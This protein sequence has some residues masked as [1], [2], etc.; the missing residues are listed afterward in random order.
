[1]LLLECLRLG[2]RQQRASDLAR[3]NHQSVGW[4]S[5]SVDQAASWLSL[6]MSD[7]ADADFT[8]TRPFDWGR[9]S[10]LRTLWLGLI[11]VVIT[12]PLWL[13]GEREASAEICVVSGS[14]YMLIA[15]TVQWSM[16][17]KSGHRCVHGVRLHHVEFDRLTLVSPPQSGHVTIQG[18]AF[19]YVAQP[20]FD[21]HDSF[22]LTVSGAVSKRRGSSTILVTVSVVGAHRGLAAAGP[23]DVPSSGFPDATN[24]GVPLGAALTP[25]GS[26][27]ISTAGAVVSGLD[28]TGEVVITAPNVTLRNCKVRATTFVGI[29][30]TG[31]GALIENCEVM[32]VYANGSTKGIWF[33]DTATGSTVRKCNIHDVEDGVYVSTRNIAVTDN[34][35]HDLNSTGFDPHYDGIQ[36]H[37]GVTSDVTIHHNSVVVAL[38][39]NSAITMGTVQNVLIDGNRLSGGGYTI[40][41]DGRFGEGTVSRVFITNNRFG[42]HTVDHMTFERATPVISGNVDDVTGKPL[43]PN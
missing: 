3:T 29:Y 15:E 37:G 32:S 38:D 19:T 11:T 17:I 31:S 34:Y 20:D 26:I 1:M 30:V 24:T 7:Q 41:V 6:H 36:L 8:A 18:P 40:H 27:T 13:A 21:G 14:R 22:V 33:D 4:R 39:S 23:L 42:S 2:A 10:R 12:L 5:F 28:I 25:S 35:I 43:I 16:R 9:H